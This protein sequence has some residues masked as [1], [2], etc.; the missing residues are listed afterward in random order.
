MQVNGL[1]RTPEVSLITQRSQVQILPPLPEKVQV[2]G[3]V[4]G[5]G[6]RPL[7]LKVSRRS[8]VCSCRNQEPR[9]IA[10]AEHA[11]TSITG[12]Q[13]RRIDRGGHTACLSRP[14]LHHDAV[15]WLQDRLPRGAAGSAGVLVRASG[16]VACPLSVDSDP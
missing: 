3:L 12:S 16:R 8:A 2:K 7:T 4:T 15:I 14:D 10:H 11:H 5:N 13:L 9:G 1:L 6:T